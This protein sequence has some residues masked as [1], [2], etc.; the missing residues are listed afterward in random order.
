VS[1]VLLAAMA[2]LTHGDAIR[3]I[4][5]RW[6]TTFESGNMSGREEIYPAVWG[7]FLERPLFGWG[8]IIN[9]VELGARLHYKEADCRDPHNVWLMILTEAGIVGAAPF[10]AGFYLCYSAA[11]RARKGPYG[12]I[13]LAVMNVTFITNLTAT[14]YT[15]KS[16]WLFLALA[17]ACGDRGVTRGVRSPSVT[18]HPLRL[19]SGDR[20]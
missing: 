12:F 7:M 8:P 11:W 9:I 5:D 19:E 13:A 20:P 15:T 1:L 6:D 4:T 14:Y 16:F 3:N 17:L 10:I 2:L 18:R